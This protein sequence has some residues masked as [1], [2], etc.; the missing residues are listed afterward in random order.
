MDRFEP[1]VIVSGC[2]LLTGLFT[3]A[4]G[5]GAPGLLTLV[6]LIFVAGTTMNGAQASM[7]A[8]AANYYPTSARATGVAWMMGIG[9]FCAILGALSVPEF[10]PPPYVRPGALISPRRPPLITAT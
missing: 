4:I 1:N 7:S 5:Y 10:L 6:C 8:L 9:R 2:F 3:V